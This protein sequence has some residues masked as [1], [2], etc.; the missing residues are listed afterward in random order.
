MRGR[1]VVP[2]WSTGANATKCTWVPLASSDNMNVFNWESIA[3]NPSPKSVAYGYWIK[4]EVLCEKKGRLAYRYQQKATRRCQRSGRGSVSN[5]T[6]APS[7]ANVNNNEPQLLP[8]AFLRSPIENH[9]HNQPT[10]LQTAAP[11]QQWTSPGTE[12]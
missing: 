6:K 1:T 7:N 10:V 9:P 8:L 12:Q 4:A 5:D 2:R 11:H 3:L